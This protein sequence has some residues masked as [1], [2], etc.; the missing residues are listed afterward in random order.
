LSEIERG[1][2]ALRVNSLEVRLTPEGDARGR[3]A[4]VVIRATPQQADTAVGEVTIDVNVA[5]P[6][7]A[8][9]RMGMKQDFSSQ[10]R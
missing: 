5:G 6:L 9:L 10:V 1:K 8:V 7:A 4:S 2:L 3:S